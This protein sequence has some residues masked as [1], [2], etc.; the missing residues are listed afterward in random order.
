MNPIAVIHHIES[1]NRL[2]LVDKK[3]SF[4]VPGKQMYLP[5]LLIDLKE[6]GNTPIDQ[7]LKM[8]PASQLLIL[9]HL[10]VKTLENINLRN[11]AEKL[12]YN[13]MTITRSASYLDFSGL[14]SLKGNREKFLQFNFSGKELWNKVEPLMTN[15]VKESDLV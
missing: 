2:R 5:A 3:I 8:S 6:F 4:I 11:I 15:P 13:A 10:Q 9:Y 14:C 1:Y 7:P 12:N